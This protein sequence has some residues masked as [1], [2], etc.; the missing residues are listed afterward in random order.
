MNKIIIGVVVVVAVVAVGYAI[1]KNSYTAP[2]SN[3]P[4]S[5]TNPSV[6]TTPDSVNITG[7]AFQPSSLTVKA[8]TTVTWVNQDSVGHNIKSAAFSSQDLQKGDTFKFTFNTKGTFAY[9]CGIHPSMVG[10]IVVE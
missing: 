7:F 2:G 8:G 6:A 1:M 9:N 10:T 5:Q 4:A 3:V